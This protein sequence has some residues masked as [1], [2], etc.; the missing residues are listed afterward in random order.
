MCIDV[1]QDILGLF[2]PM[3]FLNFGEVLIPAGEVM[4][5]LVKVDGELLELVFGHGCLNFFIVLF[6]QLATS[7]DSCLRQVSK[8]RSTV[9][10]TIRAKKR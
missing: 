8:H 3:I 1:G 9:G 6:R 7:Y 4:A 5:L 10:W 2:P